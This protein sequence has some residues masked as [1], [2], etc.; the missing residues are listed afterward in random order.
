MS[1]IWTRSRYDSQAEADLRQFEVSGQ[2]PAAAYPWRV[3]PMTKSAGRW[4]TFA[5]CLLFTRHVIRPCYAS[6]WTFRGLGNS[7]GQAD[8]QP[9]RQP[10]PLIY[11][12]DRI[13][14]LPSHH[15][16]SG[17]FIYAV[18][19]QLQD[20]LSKAGRPNDGLLVLPSS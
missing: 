12:D 16:M 2:A 15:Y 6:G 11:Y 4:S 5:T 19:V 20:S 9:H 18:L 8:G 3:E 13:T 7:H 17:I 14:I 10:S 1:F